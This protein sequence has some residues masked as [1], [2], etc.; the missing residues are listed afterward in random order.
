MKDIWTNRLSEYLDGELD[1]T[2]RA[3]L[4]AHLASCGRCYATL[5]ELRDVVA[6]AKTLVDREPAKDLWAGIR[7][8]LT[9]DAPIP[10]RRDRPVRRRFSLTVG[11]LLAA[12]IAL[13][14]MSGSGMWL[15]LRHDVTPRP[16]PIVRRG[17][18]QS[19]G[20]AVNVNT[21]AWKVR[22]DMAIAELQDALTLNE[23]KLDTATVRI[24]RENLAVI[25]RAISQAQHALRR[26]P[27]NTYLNLHLAKAMRQKIELL[28]RANALAES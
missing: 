3:A 14:L 27:G 22:S 6:H 16:T 18:E 13:V 20:R 28:R 15:A 12:S 24:V 23:S 19:E 5:A 25:D 10:L 26:D 4:E 7:A 11:Q 2:E 17:A 8:G 9:T 1:A 21:E